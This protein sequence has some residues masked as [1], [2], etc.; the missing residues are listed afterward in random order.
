MIW[1]YVHKL[2]SL[3]SVCLKIVQINNQKIPHFVH[4]WYKEVPVNIM[5]PSTVNKIDEYLGESISPTPINIY[6]PK[7][8]Y[9]KF[10][11]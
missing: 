3:Y 10:Q 8:K 6:H 2:F 4:I 7:V 1:L 9:N 5:Y 11:K